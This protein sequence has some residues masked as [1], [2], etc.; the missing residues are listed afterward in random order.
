MN[1]IKTLAFFIALLVLSTVAVTGQYVKIH[2]QH[3]CTSVNTE[4]DTSQE[5]ENLLD[6]A[7]VSRLNAYKRDTTYDN[8]ALRR[9]NNG[10]L[11]T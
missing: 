9:I 8:I 11:Y 2:K 1:I 5:S 3:I 4:C 7:T 10:E 6:Q